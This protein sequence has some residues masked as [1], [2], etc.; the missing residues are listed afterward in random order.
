MFLV[1]WIFLKLHMPTKT[2]YPVTLI[3][4]L[5]WLMVS[6][7]N[8]IDV[9]SSSFSIGTKVFTVT[10]TD[11]ENDQLFYNMTCVPA[12]CGP[13]KIYDCKH[14]LFRLE[15]CTVYPILYCSHTFGDCTIVIVAITKIEEMVRAL[16]CDKFI[17]YTSESHDT[18]INP[19]IGL[20]CKI[21]EISPVV[22]ETRIF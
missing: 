18:L 9:A 12:S 17:W 7:Q 15:Q 16:I 5:L 2:I 22:L 1:N 3:I 21:V 4:P 19:F 14:N 11:R 13:F 20:K 6:A 10:S 8:S